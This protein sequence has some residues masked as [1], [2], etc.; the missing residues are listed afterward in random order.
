MVTYSLQT[1]IKFEIKES[2][3]LLLLLQKGI[4]LLTLDFVR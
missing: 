3:F 4:F 1:L 2:W